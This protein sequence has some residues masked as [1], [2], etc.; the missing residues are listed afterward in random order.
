M[1]CFHVGRIDTPWHSS[2]VHDMSSR[3]STKLSEDTESVT[4]PTTSSLVLLSATHA[5]PQR[6]AGAFCC[7]GL[8]HLRI[9]SFPLLLCT[10]PEWKPPPALL[11]LVK[12]PPPRLMDPPPL[13]KPPLWK[14]PLCPVFQ[15]L[16]CPSVPML[17]IF[18][19]S[20]YLRFAADARPQTN[21]K[22][23]ALPDHHSLL[24]NKL[25][26]VTAHSLSR[27]CEESIVVSE[28]KCA[29]RAYLCSSLLF[30]GCAPR[31]EF[32]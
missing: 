20:C 24:L 3:F 27:G 14:P 29:R 10:A 13:W 19:R 4:P 26:F 21:K 23:A 15:W 16:P 6:G 30:R 12:P 28:G 25:A 17:F 31:Q 9:G 2:S 8:Y 32:S 11:K 18:A 22:L 5:C 7:A 1:V